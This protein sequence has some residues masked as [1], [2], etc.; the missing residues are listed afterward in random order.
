MKSQTIAGEFTSSTKVTLQDICLPE[1]MSNRTFDSIEARVIGTDC[2]YDMIIGRDALRLFKLNLLFKENIIE[3][4]DISIP[5]RPFPENKTTM[6]SIAETMLIEML[7]QEIENDFGQIMIW[8]TQTI[9]RTYK[10]F[11]PTI[12]K[13]TLNTPLFPR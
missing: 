7:E 1:F 12:L 6:F 9:S 10:T 3:M 5:M 11:K 13:P 2:R 8:T 4:E